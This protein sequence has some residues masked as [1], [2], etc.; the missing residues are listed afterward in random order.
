VIVLYNAPAF[1]STL[2]PDPM[3]TMWTPVLERYPNRPRFEAIADA[4][5]DAISE[6]SLKAGDRLPTHRELAE[7]LGVSLGTV[8]RAYLRAEERGLTA[9]EVGRG[10]FVR[11][12]ALADKR[13][14]LDVMAGADASVLDLSVLVPPATAAEQLSAG[15]R[16]A[17]AGLLE[18]GD[19]LSVLS[20][21]RHM[22][23]AAH[24]QAGADW[25][26]RTGLEAR[27]DEVLVCASGQH[28]AMVALSALTRPG[29]TIFTEALTSPLLKDIAAWLELKLQGLPMDAE[30]LEPEAFAAA[31]RTGAARVLFCMPTVHTPTAARQ[32]SGRRRELAAIAAA[33]DIAIIEDGVLGLLAPD[34]GPP[35]S[36]YAPDQG[37]YL[38]SLSKT[39]APGLRVGYLRAPARWREAFEFA[40]RASVWMASPLAGEI[41]ARWISDGTADRIV[42][43]HRQEAGV[44]QMVA[45]SVLGRWSYDCAPTGYHLW[46]HLPEPWRSSEFVATCR[47]RGVAVT[48]PEVFVPGRGHAP[49]AVRICLG[50]PGS[51]TRLEEG[52]RI[53]ASVLEASA[54]AAHFIV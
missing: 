27:A 13:G 40:I 7:R 25:L 20:Y 23:S 51:R 12:S 42:A 30:G 18:D 14:F 8:T 54:P 22:G 5:R 37:C 2:A 16:A 6:G 45:S 33:Y 10:T 36:A 15:L 31:C 48:S 49:H 53:I 19:G 11:G 35:L 3:M 52:L 28:A 24:R 4:L 34:A 50:R 41:A 38:T 47:Q 26:A 17:V 32:S 43:A 1:V 44:R 9:G 21:H 46:L 39:I 29:D